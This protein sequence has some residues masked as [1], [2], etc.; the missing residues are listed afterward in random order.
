M[1]GLEGFVSM[2]DWLGKIPPGTDFSLMPEQY[3]ASGSGIWHPH[4]EHARMLGLA[5]WQRLP[6]M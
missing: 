3:Q 6:G 2:D 5:G 1:L 4:G